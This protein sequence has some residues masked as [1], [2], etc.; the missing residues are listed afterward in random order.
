M[1]T[2]I[3]ETGIKALLLRTADIDFWLR[4]F[5]TSGITMVVIATAAAAMAVWLNTLKKRR[6]K[7]QTNGGAIT[8]QR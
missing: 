5:K 2:S 4:V 8:D 6:E 7:P 3:E 1:L